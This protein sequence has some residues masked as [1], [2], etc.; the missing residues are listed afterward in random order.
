MP[1]FGLHI[2]AVYKMLKKSVLGLSLFLTLVIGA[3]INKDA[4]N[5]STTTSLPGERLAQIHCGSCHKYPTPDLL[6]K[7]TWESYVL[8]RMGYFLGIYPN[9]TIRNMLIEQGPGGQLVETAKIFPE[10]PALDIKT[11][12]AIERFY[13]ETAPDTLKLPITKESTELKQFNVK[14]PDFALSPPSTTLLQFHDNGL[15]LGDANSKG[16]YD[17]DKKFNIQKAAKVKEGA[18]SSFETNEALYITVMGSFSPT[19][20]PT[21]FVMSLPKSGTQQP[22]ILVD[23]LQRPVHSAVADLNGD[24]RSDMVISEFAKWTGGLSWWEQEADG[25]FKEHPL[26][27]VPGAIKTDIRD[28]NDD[29]LL[30]ILAL[31]GQGD[32]GFFLFI[33]E[34][35]GQFKSQRVLQLESVMGSSSFSIIDYN[36]D[37]KPDILYTAGDNADYPPVLKPYHGI[38]IYENKGDQRFEQAFFYPMPGAYGAIA[39][40]YDQDGDL[41]IAAI[42]FFPDFENTPEDGFVYFENQ[43]AFDMKT[44]HFPQ[45]QLGRW[46]VMDAG[47]PDQDGDID[48]ALGSLAFEV[49]PDRGEIERWVQNGLPFLIL[50]NQ[51]K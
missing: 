36:Q 24:G 34:G 40:D 46:I 12:R 20:A 37:Q 45:S 10:E 19:D 39:K 43:G 2:N 27:A 8:P 30:D 1:T 38:Y 4:T 28:Y 35:N 15:Y 5:Q 9:D 11:W 48:L 26:R 16:F 25:Q 22:Y 47:D 17:I 51:L 44:F 7:T 29:G 33:N 42:S 6:P 13:L 49:V 14:F 3:C 18:V 31:F 41:D 32:E 21:G 23:Q 50:E